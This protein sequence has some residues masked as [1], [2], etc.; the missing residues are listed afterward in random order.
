MSNI[1]VVIP[2]R[3]GSTRIP[4][5]MLEDIGGVPLVV[6]T[7]RGCR[8]LDVHVLV[9][10]DCVDIASAVEGECSRAVMTGECASGT[11]RVF[12]AIEDVDSSQRY[13]VVVNVQGDMPTVTGRAIL[14]AVS[15]LDGDEFD[16]GTVVGPRD[17]SVVS[18]P[19][20]PLALVSE[21]RGLYF[22]RSPVP[23]GLPHI[24]IYAFRRRALDLFASLSPGPLEQAER[25]EQFRLLENG[26]SVGVSR[27]DEMISGIDEPED[28]ANIRQVFSPAAVRN[29]RLA[30]R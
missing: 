19:S 1:A 13:D 4:G 12:A 18:D 17:P 20:V 14:A 26:I 27:Y 10:T 7:V 8:D 2:A 11:D 5:K 22:T 23:Y 15:A 3:R 29:S 25:L 6:R 21:M 9:A 30:K 24:G 16:V 28:L